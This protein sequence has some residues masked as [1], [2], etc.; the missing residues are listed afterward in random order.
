MDP[1]DTDWD[2]KNPYD[3]W[4]AVTHVEGN[5][6]MVI[7]AEGETAKYMTLADDAKIYYV[8]AYK[9]GENERI[10]VSEGDGVIPS[11]D[12]G[13]SETEYANSVIYKTND[14]G[15]ITHIIVE[16]HGEEI[17]NNDVL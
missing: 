3:T 13:T 8:D 11:A 5:S 9:S 7:D 16:I 2:G 1:T 4:A 15:E 6:L 14:D 10:M 17:W 12:I